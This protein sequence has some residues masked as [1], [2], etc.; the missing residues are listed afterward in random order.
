MS[1]GSQILQPF[2]VVGLHCDSVPASLQKLGNVHFATT[3]IDKTFQVYN[4][5]L[6]SNFRSRRPLC[7]LDVLF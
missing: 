4:V 1:T 7:G 3:S 2:R 5:R 6:L